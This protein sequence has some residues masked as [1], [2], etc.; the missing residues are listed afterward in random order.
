MRIGFAIL[1]HSDP[2]QM[3]RLISAL[4]RMFNRPSIAIHHDFSQC[5]LDQK[6]FPDNVRFVRSWVK[7]AWAAPTLIDA[8]LLAVRTLY[9]MPGAP[10]WFVLLSGAC[11][12]IKPAGKIIED[13]Q[14]ARC[15]AFIDHTWVRPED[16]A[17][18]EVQLGLEWH[19]VKYIP[20]PF[21]P[22]HVGIE[23]RRRIRLPHWASK[24][25]LPWGQT[26]EG[27]EIRCYRGSQW[28]S[29]N[30]KAAEFMLKDSALQ[31]TL[32]RYYRHAFLPD[33][34]F[35]QSLLANEPS[36]V[37]TNDYKRYI[38]WQ[39]RG[40]ALPNVLRPDD[41]PRLMKSPAHFARKFSLK[42]FPEMYDALDRHLGL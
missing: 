24:P 37:C 2:E 10:D 13:F 17:D 40:E 5:P 41:W 25:F 38:D 31:R 30:W 26:A 3:H 7:T 42:R 15:D 1:T 12:P 11:Y 29:A 6:R 22:R 8:M 32:W 35:F 27:R 34:G 4:T 28:F 18:P 20:V 36:L 14:S 39:N 21:L 9:Q 33:E 23:V 16:S 19:W